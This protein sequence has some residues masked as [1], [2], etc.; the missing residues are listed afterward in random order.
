MYIIHLIAAAAAE[1]DEDNK[2]L[3]LDNKNRIQTIRDGARHS[4]GVIIYIIYIYVY[5]DGY[6]LYI[7][8]QFCYRYYV[9]CLL[10]S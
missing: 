3:H 6:E 8:V 9:K 4:R 5:T 10:C 1:A 2:C 7:A